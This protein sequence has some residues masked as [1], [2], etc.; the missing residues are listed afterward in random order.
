MGSSQLGM[1]LELGTVVDFE[2]QNV[3]SRGP[4]GLVDDPLHQRQVAVPRGHH[5]NGVPR[6]LP[7]RARGFVIMGMQAAAKS[8]DNPGQANART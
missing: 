5:V 8:E 7:G 2:N 1:R 6:S 4:H 3:D